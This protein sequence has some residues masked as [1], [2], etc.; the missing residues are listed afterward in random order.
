MIEGNN[1]LA[2]KRIFLELSYSYEG[3]K[4]ASEK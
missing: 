3:N 1:I 4:I 2:E